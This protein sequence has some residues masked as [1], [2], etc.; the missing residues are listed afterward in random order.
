LEHLEPLERLEPQSQWNDWNDWNNWNSRFLKRF[1]QSAC[2]ERLGRKAVERLERFER[3]AVNLE[4]LTAEGIEHSKA[5]ELLERLERASVLR[6][7]EKIRGIRNF[8][9][10]EGLLPLATYNG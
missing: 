2:P 5:V 6:R 7:V 3:L 8:I 4:L 9:S 1:E 10:R